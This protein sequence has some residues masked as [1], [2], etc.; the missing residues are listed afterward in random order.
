MS[1][2]GSSSAVIPVGFSGVN[3]Q[4]F[5]GDGS[6]VAFTLNRPVSAAKDVEVVVNNVQ[7]SPYDSSYSVSGTTLTFSAAP[8]SGTA[9]I[10]VTYRDQPVGSITDTGAVQKTGDT[11]TGDLI[12][13]TKLGVGIDSPIARIHAF[14]RASSGLDHLGSFVGGTSNTSGAGA[15]I[16]I[17]NA[18][19][20]SRGVR[21]GGV[22]TSG[23]TGA[24][25]MVLYTN[26]A[27]TA[28]EER[29]RITSNGYLRLA[30]KGIQ[31]NGDTAAANALDDYEEGTW[32]PEFIALSGTMQTVNY[33]GRVGKY[34]KIG[35]VVHADFVVSWAST[36]GTGSGLLALS[37]PF[38]P[39]GNGYAHN[40]FG[41]ISY[42][43]G[44]PTTAHFYGDS[45]A[46]RAILIKANGTANSY[47]SPSE[48]SSGGGQIMGRFIF[49]TT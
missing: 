16:G 4:S 1:Y 7:Q 27:S 29:V 5:N 12:V 31:F 23:N 25:D 18:T 26:I 9:N 33:G 2:I 36:S 15:Y 48:I 20:T 3:S 46:T 42:A 37:M 41:G 38:A 8:S 10:Y 30:D 21:I 40:G 45:G 28:P 49:H 43:S 14:D 6:T 47:Y 44:L 22:N 13:D 24:H 19:G 17:G 32:T 11:M 35:N 34:T 39:Y